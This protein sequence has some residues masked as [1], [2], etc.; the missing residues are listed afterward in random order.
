[1]KTHFRSWSM[2]LALI[3][4]GLVTMVG[5]FPLA[6][7]AGPWYVAPNGDDISSCTSPSASCKTINGAIMKEG[8]ALGIPTPVN[9]LLTALIKIL[10]KTY[11]RQI[12]LPQ[13]KNP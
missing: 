11:A 5:S 12:S 3:S 8:Q 6:H 7:A 2:R 4:T 1:M 13:L 9:E 10:E